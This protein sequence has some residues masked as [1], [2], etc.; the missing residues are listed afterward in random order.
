MS[1]G[2]IQLKKSN[3]TPKNDIFGRLGDFSVRIIQSFYNNCKFVCRVFRAMYYVLRG[4][5]DMRRVDLW[6]EID[7]AGLRAIPIVCLISLNQL[8]LCI[9][10]LLL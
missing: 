6:V 10:Q 3:Q 5:G 7:A 8:W 2:R 4:R 9:K 1:G